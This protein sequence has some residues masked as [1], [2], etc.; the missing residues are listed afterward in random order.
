MLDPGESVLLQELC[1]TV[2]AIDSIEAQ[3]AADGLT[4]TGDRGQVP[5]AHPLLFN[6][7]EHRKIASRLVAELALPMPGEQVGQRRTPQQKAAVTKL[8]FA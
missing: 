4:V 2:D 6:L 8:A 1:R 7:I 5:R 3:L